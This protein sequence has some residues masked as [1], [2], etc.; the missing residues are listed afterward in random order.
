MT[1]IWPEPRFDYRDPDIRNNEDEYLARQRDV[2]PVIRSEDFGGFWAL[3]KFADIAEAANDHERFTTTV[4]PT[5]PP[6]G[7]PYGSKPLTSDPPEHGVYRKLLQPFFSPAATAA[8]EPLVR[9]IVRERIAEFVGQGKGDLMAELGEPVPAQVMAVLLGLDRS[10]SQQISL[11]NKKTQRSSVGEDLRSAEEVQAEILRFLTEEIESRRAGPRDDLLSTIVHSEVD[12]EPV[13]DEIRYGMATM[14]IVAG[15]DTTVS[16]IV[17]TLFH[18]S[19]YGPDFRQA[20]LDDPEKLDLFV[21]EALRFD[22]PV[23]GLARSVVGDVC[24][25]D[26]E[27]KDGD[28][29]L[30]LWG[31]GNHD[32]ERFDDPDTFDPDRRPAANLTFGW[33][34]HRCLGDKLAKLE[35]RVVVEEVLAAMPEFRRVTDDPPPLRMD[36]E[37]GPSALEVVW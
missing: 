15:T 21:N 7:R 22:A 3:T 10:R 24:L 11:M 30:L 20:L 2:C 16:G 33:G 35:I 19:R 17:N 5:I 8:M 31:S 6:Y 28:R 9:T 34:R 36:L 25:R 32:A 27:M 26:V 1:N 37:H 18:V 23:F 4:G 29:V 13:T 14:L 12:G